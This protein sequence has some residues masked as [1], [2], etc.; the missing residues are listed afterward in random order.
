MGPVNPLAGLQQHRLEVCRPSGVGK[1]QRNLTEEWRLGPE[2]FG[3]VPCGLDA[4]ADCTLFF[5]AR[6]PDQPQALTVVFRV[7][8]MAVLSS[9][10]VRKNNPK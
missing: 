2:D 10:Q 9:I 5:L 6:A 8:V 4:A 7:C 1:A 3:S